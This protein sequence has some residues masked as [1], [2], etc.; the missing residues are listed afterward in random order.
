MF[1]CSMCDFSS[2]RRGDVSLH[3]KSH[4]PFSCKLC[5]KGFAYKHVLKTHM[6][7]HS[8]VL[9]HSCP[10]CSK[11]FRYKQSLD[12][13]QHLPHINIQDSEDLIICTSE[14]YRC[15]ICGF[16]S[17]RRKDVTVHLKSHKPFSCKMCGKRF[18]YKHVLKTHM[19]THSEVLPHSCPICFKGF[20]HK[21]SLDYHQHLHFEKKI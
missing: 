20:R 21:Q 16:S 19:L 10:I 8:E 17:K 2:K 12:Y 1:Y 9:P 18:A 5:G 4:K 6:L 13:H 11:R 7:T 15:S 14:M 3:L